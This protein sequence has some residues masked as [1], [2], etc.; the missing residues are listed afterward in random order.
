MY[1]QKGK[2]YL[3]RMLKS[4][5]P[6]PL[7]RFSKKIKPFLIIR[8]ILFVIIM[9]LR[10]YCLAWL[11]FFFKLDQLCPPRFIIMH[12]F[13]PNYWKILHLPPKHPHH[14]MEVFNV[15]RYH[16]LILHFST[17]HFWKGQSI[18]HIVKSNKSWSFESFRTCEY[19]PDNFKL[20]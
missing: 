17:L 1:F 20:Y 18:F 6:A 9:L 12:C 7:F 14:L 3:K 5:H 13:D 15:S 4:N 10:Q 19:Y 16:F 11:F 2:F 8:M